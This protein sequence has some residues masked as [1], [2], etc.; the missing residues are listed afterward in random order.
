MILMNLREDTTIGRRRPEHE[1]FFMTV[2][3]QSEPES[4]HATTCSQMQKNGSNRAHNAVKFR[5]HYF[6]ASRHVRTG[7]EDIRS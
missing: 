3:R 5:I 2:S 4:I 7:T 6:C 1:W